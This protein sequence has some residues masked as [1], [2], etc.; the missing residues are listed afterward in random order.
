MTPLDMPADDVTVVDLA[1]PL[2]VG[3]PASPTHPPFEFAL[4]HRHGDVPYP[5]GL[6][7]SHEIMMLG[8]HVGTHMDALSHVAVDGRLHGGVPVADAMHAGRYTSHGIDQVRPLFC[9]GVLYDLPRLRKVP[10]LAPG[11]PVGVAD[12]E[13][14]PVPRPGDVALIRTGWAQLWDD[15]RAYV[16]DESGVPGLDLAAAAW[17][18]ERGVAAVGA[19]T[20]ALEQRPPGPGPTGLPVHRLLLHEHGINLIEVLEL[21][22]LSETLAAAGTE[23]FLFVGAPLKVVGATGA[24]I[25]PLAV[26]GA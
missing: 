12:L 17:L 22:K 6:T 14:G 13:A 11:A 19:D 24:P 21:E 20:I 15:P 25:R 10:R 9:R 3:M 26:V 1:Q 7:G 5:D 8:G 2:E 18:A 16:G 4:R 23:E